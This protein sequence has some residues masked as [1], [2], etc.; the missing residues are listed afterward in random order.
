MSKGKQVTGSTISL[1][2]Q[3]KTLRQLSVKDK[4]L[5]K[6]KDVWTV[7]LQKVFFWST[8]LCNF[9]KIYMDES[10]QKFTECSINIYYL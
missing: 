1:Q 10:A 7:H 6:K 3:T 5:Y 9:L 4:F 8:C 2:P